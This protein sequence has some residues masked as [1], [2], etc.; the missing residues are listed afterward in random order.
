MLSCGPGTHHNCSADGLQS[1]Q[2]NW[3]VTVPMALN[4]PQHSAQ[5]SYF[6]NKTYRLLM[7]SDGPALPVEKLAD[8]L[9]WAQYNLVGDHTVGFELAW[10]S[11]Q[12][13]LPMVSD[14]PSVAGRTVGQANLRYHLKNAGLIEHHQQNV[15][16]ATLGPFEA[17]YPLQGTL[18][19]LE[20]ISTTILKL[21]PLEIISQMFCQQHWGHLGPSVVSLVRNNGPIQ[22]HQYGHL[23]NCTGP[24]KDHQ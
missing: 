2:R 22:G 23:P 12:W 21:G 7:A 24:I 11:S 13:I 14:E 19:P 3:E 20:T 9:Q 1:A 17:Q 8:D 18:N 15:P 6:L 5:G 10:H 4:G 16:L